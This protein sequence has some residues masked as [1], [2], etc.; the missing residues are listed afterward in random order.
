MALISLMT[1]WN[2]IEA[3]EQLET[4]HSGCLR[5]TRASDTQRVPTI[6]LTKEGS[7]LT[8]DLLNYENNCGTV[9][10]DVTSDINA[11]GDGEPVTVSASVVPVIP[12]DMDCVCPYNISFTIRDVPANTFYFSCWWYHGLVELADGEPLVLENVKEDAIIEGLKYKLVRAMHTAT[13][14]DAT[15]WEG[16]LVIPQTVSYQGEEYQVTELKPEAFM[17]NSTLTK[18]CIPSTAKGFYQNPF[19]GCTALETI[20]V[21]S[22]NPE[23]CA[24]DGVLF[25]KE[26][27][28]LLSYPAGARRT[29]YTVP[30]GV[31]WVEGNA[32]ACSQ[33]LVKVTLHDEVTSLGYS[34]FADSKSLE[35][36]RLSAGL[37]VL[38]W[39][40]FKNCQ[41]LKS[42]TIP[43][44]VT[45]ICQQVFGGC[46]SLTS[47]TMPESVEEA[48]AEVFFDCKSLKSVKLSS[49]LRQI[50]YGMFANC[51]SLTDVLIPEGVTTIGNVAFQNCS[52]MRSLDLP[53]S[54]SRIFRAFSGCKFT[55]FYVRGIIEPSLLTTRIFDGMSTQAKVYVQPSEVE[56]FKAIYKGSVYPLQQAGQPN[57]ISDIVHSVTGEAVIFDLQGRRIDGKPVRGLY[58]MN[59]QK[60]I[61][62]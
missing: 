59:G 42:V 5:D 54:V 17:N 3:Q 46:S 9:D 29:S 57:D 16:E 31:T 52:A 41:R 22:G 50:P 58:I 2:V 38:A 28:K 51:S 4:K 15:S 34:A 49:K 53:E 10:F 32:F 30:A 7:I 37:D 43:Q 1:A 18:V 48:D 6:V 27:T 24:V 40:L 47:V 25:N 13:L 35:E 19:Y 55:T 26:K 45:F 44:G 21:E 60:I 39:Y 20:E 33:Y 11:G 62:K 12:A 61:V 23:V 8:V 14:T 36:V 56:K